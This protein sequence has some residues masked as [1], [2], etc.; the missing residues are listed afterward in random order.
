MSAASPS[1]PVTSR[2]PGRKRSDRSAA[3]PTRR[4]RLP[5][6]VNANVVRVSSSSESR[7]TSGATSACASVRSA[8]QP[9]S[10]ERSIHAS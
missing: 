7:A 6:R 9:A 5:S 4:A 3:P 10:N 8:S 1:Q 2:Q